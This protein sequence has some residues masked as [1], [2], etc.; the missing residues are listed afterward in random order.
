MLHPNQRLLAGIVVCGLVVTLAGCDL[1]GPDGPNG[2]GWL[3]ADLVSPN[4]PESAVVLELVGGRD[5][6]SLA[7]EGGEIFSEQDG[8]ILRVVAVMDDPGSIRVEIRTEDVA[9]LPSVAV[10]QVADGENELRASLEG[11]EVSFT[12]VPDGQGG[13]P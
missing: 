12:K 5:L 1:F 7:L 10:I 13:G 8:N 9:K 6:S 2:P 3:Q 4:G 11:Y